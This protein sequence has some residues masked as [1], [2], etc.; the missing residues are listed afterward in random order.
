MINIMN[1]NSCKIRYKYL[2]SY[3]YY[4]LLDKKEDSSIVLNESNLR[5]VA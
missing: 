1:F 3:S 5:F 2:S 4:F